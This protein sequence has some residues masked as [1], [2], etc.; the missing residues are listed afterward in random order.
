[1]KWLEYFLEPVESNLVCS[2]KIAIMVGMVNKFF[3]SFE[4]WESNMTSI[5]S[6]STQKYFKMVK[7]IDESLY[8]F[9]KV[10]RWLKTWPPMFKGF[11]HEQT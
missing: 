2:F 8:R 6:F 10:N 11:V 1:V 4:K 5:S 7:L 3:E 9:N